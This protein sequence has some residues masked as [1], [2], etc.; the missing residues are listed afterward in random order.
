MG[1]ESEVVE[2][3]VNAMGTSID[4]VTFVFVKVFDGV[5]RV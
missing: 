5:D 2:G 1:E 3:D 4:F